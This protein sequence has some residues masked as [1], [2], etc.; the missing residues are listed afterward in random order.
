VAA[1]EQFLS[2]ASELFGPATHGVRIE[3]T[4]I[5]IAFEPESLR[6]PR[7]CRWRYAGAAGL[8][9]GGKERDISGMID[10]PSRR[11]LEPRR[12]PVEVRPQPV[13]EG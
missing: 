4:D 13:C 10:H 9:A 5:V 6:K 12:Q 8:L 7:H 2:A 11:I 3:L 1:V